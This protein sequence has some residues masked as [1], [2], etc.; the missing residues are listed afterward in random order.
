MQ[1][2]KALTTISRGTCSDAAVILSP[3]EKMAE[4]TAG[5]PTHR[6]AEAVPSI[7]NESVSPALR[8][9]QAFGRFSGEAGHGVT[10]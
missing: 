10:T 3:R 1:N 9:G 7:R 2:A 5:S 6:K 8:M 4:P